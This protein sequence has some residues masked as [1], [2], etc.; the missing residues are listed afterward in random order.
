MTQIT[1]CL[2]LK[3]LGFELY[4]LYFKVTVT[5]HLNSLLRACEPS[6]EEVV[7]NVP[8]HGTYQGKNETLKNLSFLY[9]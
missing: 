5:Q 6:V 1:C 7:K 2:K 9:L 3:Y 4:G 8:N